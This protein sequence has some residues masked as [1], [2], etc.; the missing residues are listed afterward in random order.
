MIILDDRETDILS[1]FRPYGDVDVGTTRLEFGDFRWEGNGSTGPILIGAERKKVPDLISSMRD[2]RLAGLQAA[3]LSQEC[4]IRY[5]IIE[6][7]W[8]M[9]KTGAIEILKG[10][11]WKPIGG[12]RI[13]PILWR[14]LDSFISSLEEFYGLRVKHTQNMQETA[15]FIVSRYSYWN[16]KYDSHRTHKQCYAPLPDRGMGKKV[17]FVSIEEQI[18]R[19]C[20]EKA[21]FAWRM[22]AQLPGIDMKAEQVARYFKKPKW[23]FKGTE[24]DW[25]RA[26]LGPKTIEQA[27]EILHGE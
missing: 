27:M 8:R 4:D 13:K 11:D 1:S 12:S 25:R 15:A 16:K 9:G 19:E 26:G 18:R 20:G 23:M 5:L 10:R 2:R 22:A 24:S 21:V 14:E 6:G 17:A 3:G 7:I